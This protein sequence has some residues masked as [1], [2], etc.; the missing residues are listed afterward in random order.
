MARSHNFLV[1]PA[2]IPAGA[3]RVEAAALGADV[4]RH[5][6]ALR[7]RTGEAVR[8]LDGAGRAWQARCEREKPLAFTLHDLVE[9]PAL[10]PALQLFLAPPKGDALSEAV[11]QATE[12]GVT[13][14]FFLRAEHAQYPGRG[15]PPVER[16]RRVSDSAL[17]QCG[18]AWRCHIHEG[19]HELGPSLR[20]SAVHVV[21]DEATAEPGQAAELIGFTGALPNLASVS[22]AQPLRLYV[23]PEGGWSESE[24]RLFDGR[25]ATL[26]LGSLVLRVPT[27]VV[28]GAHFLRTV[29]WNLSSV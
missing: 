23:G 28:A 3:A 27:A 13:E 12:I 8:L 17:E 11:C 10:R 21:A 6:T 1:P 18:R 19:W 20:E 24:R 9:V 22:L 15:D 29:Y 4:Q 14:I 7:I 25:A 2:A 16:A 26:A 5:L